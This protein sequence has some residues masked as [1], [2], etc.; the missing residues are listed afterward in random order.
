MLHGMP[1]LE[2]RQIIDGL[3]SPCSRSPRNGVRAARLISLWKQHCLPSMGLA[4]PVVGKSGRLCKDH[5]VS[6]FPSEALA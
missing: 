4:T 1:A 2:K 5:D 6:D 3:Y